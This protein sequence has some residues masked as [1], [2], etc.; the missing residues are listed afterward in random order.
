MHYKCCLSRSSRNV[1]LLL[2]HKAEFNVQG[3]KY[4]TALQVALAPNH[5][6]IENALYVA[7]VL[8]DHVADYPMLSV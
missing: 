8:L 5:P 3:G 2:H 4:G 1:W 7:E 6:D